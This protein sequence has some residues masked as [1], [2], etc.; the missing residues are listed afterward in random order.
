MKCEHCGAEL[1]DTARVCSACGKEV[2]AGRRA[3]GETVH[4]AK[5][6]GAVAE[7]IGKGLW[8]GAKAVGAAAKKEVKGK[9]EKKD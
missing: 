2:G 6:A 4:V 5:E 7:K 9:D 8:G 1:A 3:A